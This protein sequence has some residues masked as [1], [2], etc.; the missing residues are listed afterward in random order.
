MNMAGMRMALAALA[1]GLAVLAAAPRA[2]AQSGDCPRWGPNAAGQGFTTAERAASEPSV[3]EELSEAEIKSVQDFLAREIK[4]GPVQFDAEA[5][6][7]NFIH[8]MWLEVPPKDAVLDH[9]DRGGPK[10]ERRARVITVMGAEKPPYVQEVIVGPL[11]N[12]TKWA[13]ALLNATATRL[14]FHMRPHSGADLPGQVYLLNTLAK[15]L[16]TFF[17]EAFDVGYGENCEPN[18]A[19]DNYANV[20][21]LSPEIPRALWLWFVRPTQPNGDGNFLHP[22][23]LQVAI[24]QQGQNIADWRI[25]KV[26]FWGNFF[27][28]P[29]ELAAEW[30]KP[31]SKLRALKIK[32]P[33]GNEALYSNFKRRP[34]SIRGAQQPLGPVQYEPYG[35]RFTIKGNK[36]EWLGWSMYVG[37]KPTSGMR[38]WDIRFKGER[39]VYELSLQEEMAAYGGDD[40]VQSHTIYLDSHWG[41]G[42]SVRE[43][44]HGVDC[45]LT[46]AYM[47]STTLYKV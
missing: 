42:A 45:P 15:T 18:C 1:V 11:P 26:W 19:Y 44:V 14:P 41:V 35:R 27:D 23:P 28:S 21:Y 3:F 47:D 25:V 32:Y 22:L 34:G 29:E 36:V 30:A 12:P 4:T 43:L 40:I 6:F 24:A 2:A 7:R 17:R 9:L 13:P 16:K 10:P 37:N 39:I 31:D 33:T 46:A 5:L 38:L 20:G 8:G